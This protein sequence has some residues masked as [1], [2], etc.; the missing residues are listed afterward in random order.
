MNG[1]KVFWCSNGVELA[2][3]AGDGRYMSFID[4]FGLVGVL[5]RDVYVVKP[6]YSEEVEHRRDNVKFDLTIYG[7]NARANMLKVD[8]LRDRVEIKEMAIRLPVIV[9]LDIDSVTRIDIVP[10]FL[11]GYLPI[12]LTNIKS[13]RDYRYIARF[14]KILVDDEMNIG[15]GR[16]VY[17]CIVRLLLNRMG[18]VTL[19]MR[20]IGVDIGWVEGEQL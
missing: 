3:Y 16:D 18:L 12:W 4:V 15:I 7:A 11:R 5:E 13:T 19:F 2:Y 1:K 14:A 17:E 20:R 9:R 6:D 10:E 8:M